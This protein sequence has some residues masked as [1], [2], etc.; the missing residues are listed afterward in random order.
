MYK[1][2]KWGKFVLPVELIIWVAEWKCQ[3]VEIQKI[4]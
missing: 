4:N 1:I 3:N 2:K